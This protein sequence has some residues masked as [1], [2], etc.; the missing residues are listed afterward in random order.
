MKNRDRHA[1]AV[2]RFVSRPGGRVAYD[3]VGEGPLV[4]LVPGMGDARATY[5][6]LA[7]DLASAGFRVATMDLRGHGDSDTTFARYGDGETALDV[8]AV[9][10]TLQ[11]P[12]AG[13]PTRPVVIVGSSTG[14]AAAVV[15]AVERAPLVGALV[16]VGPLV[17]DTPGGWLQRQLQ[18]TATASW[19]AAATW[20]AYLPALYAGR[21]PADYEAYCAQRVAH[22]RRPGYARGFSRMARSRHASAA[23]LLPRVAVPTLVVMGELD[24]NF[25][26]PEV[27]ARGVA[28]QV[29][30]GR[31]DLLLVPEAGH[32]P[33]AQRPDIVGPAVVAWLQ[34]L[35]GRG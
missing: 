15:V 28:E 13:V 20:R 17:R 11:A 23:N 3:V 34:Q 21:K 22:L 2:A 31:A 27:E 6:F 9:I 30:N 26:D 18:Q 10:E 29:G 25:A 12:D 4:V 19:W 14:A 24:P 16:L 35:N 32:Y 1:L 33:H 8:A 5:R 7:P